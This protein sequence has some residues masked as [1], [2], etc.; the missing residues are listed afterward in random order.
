VTRRPSLASEGR[1]RNEVSDIMI[2]VVKKMRIP[3]TIL[4]VTSMSAFRSDGHV[5]RWSDN[6]SVPDCSHWCLPGVPET[7][8]QL[9]F[10]FLLP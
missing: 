1:D 7:W 3:V 5:G 10:S 6:P 9:L 4:H 8:N 2:Q